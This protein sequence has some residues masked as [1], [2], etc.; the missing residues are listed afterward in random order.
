MTSEQL[1]GATRGRVQWEAV[2][3]VLPSSGATCWP[4][5]PTS[6]NQQRPRVD[7]ADVVI[8]ASHPLLFDA[9]WAVQHGGCGV[10]G[11]RVYVSK[12]FVASFDAAD[13][14]IWGELIIP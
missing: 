2:R 6:A 10:A 4:T 14:F 11:R 3:V 8:G 7:N 1:H 9:P 12:S 5:P 13:P